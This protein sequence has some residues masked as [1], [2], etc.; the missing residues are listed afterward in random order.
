MKLLTE[1][2]KDNIRY[3]AAEALMKVGTPAAIPVLEQRLHVESSRSVRGR[4][5]WALRI[6]RQ[7]AR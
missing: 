1:H 2:P 3:A 6:L 7:K 5:G 4:I